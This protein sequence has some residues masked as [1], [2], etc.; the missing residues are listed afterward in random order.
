MAVISGRLPA[1]RITPTGDFCQKEKRE[2]SEH[3]L[4]DN[5]HTKTKESYA[6]WLENSQNLK[7]LSALKIALSLSGIF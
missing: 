7:R 6:K 4:A 2:S 3:A 5:P 1:R